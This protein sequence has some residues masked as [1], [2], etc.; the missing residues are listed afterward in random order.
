MCIIKTQHHSWLR[1]AA[2]SSGAIH[3][4]WES[5]NSTSCISLFHLDYISTTLQL[6]FVPEIICRFWTNWSSET[7]FEHRIR[8]FQ[9]Y[10]SYLFTMYITTY[11]SMINGHDKNCYT[12]KINNYIFNIIL[13][14]QFKNY[15]KKLKQ[16]WKIN[17]FISF[18]KIKILHCIHVL[19]L[20]L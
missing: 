13:Y 1:W 2:L 20:K 5:G 12:L 8:I 4:S 7:H 14:I 15:V 11:A 6:I 3:F 9:V 16:E 17:F 19:L 10:K 18:L